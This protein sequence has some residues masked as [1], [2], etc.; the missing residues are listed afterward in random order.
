MFGE[1]PLT[2]QV[3]GNGFLVQITFTIEGNAVT[4][5]YTGTVDQNGMKRKSA[6]R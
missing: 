6:V 3:K 4:I 1:S 2:G 5:T